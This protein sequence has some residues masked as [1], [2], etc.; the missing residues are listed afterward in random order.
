VADTVYWIEFP[1]TI[2]RASLAGGGAVD[3]LYASPPGRNIA[4]GLA[5]DPAAGLIY[6]TN[7]GDHPSIRRAPL[8]GGGPV[9]T[10]YGPQGVSGP[11]GLAIDPAAGLIYWT[12]NGNNTICGAPLAGGS[13]H[14][15]YHGANPVTLPS[16]VA[17]PTG[18]TID[19]TAGRVY[20]ANA[21]AATICGAPL[22]GSGA[23]DTLY[24]TGISA[25]VGVAIDAAAGRIYWTNWAWFTNEGA[26]VGA[27]LAGRGAVD[28]LYGP[29]EVKVPGGVA[30]D[31]NAAG[32]AP[33]RLEVGDAE[34]VAIVRWL[35]EIVDWVGNPFA[36]PSV[37]PGR[38]YWS[39][40]N[41]AGGSLSDN[42]IRG[43]RLAGGGP[44]D[45]VRGSLA[46]A[47]GAIALL[48][49]PLGTG[50]PT[51]S[52]QF[53]LDDGPFGGLQFGGSHS[54]PLDQQLSCSRGTWAPDVLG[55]FLYRAPRSFAYQ[56]RLNGTDISTANSAHYT[57]TAPGSYSCRVTA[58]NEAGSTAQTSTAVTI[59]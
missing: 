30:I 36:R 16:D 22:A 2:R 10:L 7:F 31:P 29:Q 1:A 4:S 35:R 58:T 24:N 53:V 48:Q 20:W 56:W 27:P 47:A 57:P 17:G 41:T 45:T 8:A 40:G 51:I 26:I 3:T 21:V 52:W 32:S 43:A 14:T 54:G 6:W 15:L 42:A 33:A 38:I 9:D 25:P 19:P 23:V 50:A 55:S 11:F 34:R 49:A 44:V 18:M 37:P 59:S 39:N 28:T 5:I 13:V 46:A 12:D